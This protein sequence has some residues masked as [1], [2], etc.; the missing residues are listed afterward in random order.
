MKLCI[1]LVP[2]KSIAFIYGEIVKE[3]NIVIK[4]K[5]TYTYSSKRDIYAYVRLGSR[6]IIATMK[7]KFNRSLREIFFTLCVHRTFNSIVHFI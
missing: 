7:F 5:E 6:H 3:T 2:M 4:K 1:L